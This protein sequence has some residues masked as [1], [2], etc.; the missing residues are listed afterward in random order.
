M[1]RHKIKD[2]I[3]RNTYM[4]EGALRCL[5]KEKMKLVMDKFNNLLKFVKFTNRRQ[6]QNFALKK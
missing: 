4:L 1:S 2:F 5:S 3:N 6:N